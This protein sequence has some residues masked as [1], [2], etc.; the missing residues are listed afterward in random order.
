M[1]F[2]KTLWTCLRRTGA[3]LPHLTL[4]AGTVSL[5][6]LVVAA[7]ARAQEAPEAQVQFS[8]PA[9][10]LPSALLRLGEQAHVSIAVPQELVVGKMGTAVIGKMSVRAA[11][12][13]MLGP[14]GLNFEF[15][16]PDAVRIDAASF[17]RAPVHHTGLSRRKASDDDVA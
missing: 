5:I 4:H 3:L 16:G 6:L 13:R 15:V 11:L 17:P 2:H 7:T 12:K 8:V 1:S 9:Q 10:P 14:S